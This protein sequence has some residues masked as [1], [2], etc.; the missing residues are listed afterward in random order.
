MTSTGEQIQSFEDPNLQ[1]GGGDPE[2]LHSLLSTCGD[3]SCTPDK[4]KNLF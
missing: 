3:L 1:A 2:N 4:K